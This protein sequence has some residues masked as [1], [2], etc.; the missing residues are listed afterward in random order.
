MPGALFS[1]LNLIL[2][3]TSFEVDAELEKRRSRKPAI[4]ACHEVLTNALSRSS[5]SLDPV[6]S[7]LPTP[8]KERMAHWTKIFSDEKLEKT[9]ASLWQVAARKFQGFQGSHYDWRRGPK[10]AGLQT[11]DAAHSWC[12][13][14]TDGRCDFDEGSA[15][16]KLK[17]LAAK[18]EGDMSC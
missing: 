1:I 2:F 12:E 17:K 11:V 15:R 14:Q 16:G 18:V 4:C 8:L 6:G 13:S 5:F 7:N 9:E 10:V 3:W